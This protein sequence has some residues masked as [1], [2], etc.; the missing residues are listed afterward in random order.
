[1]S[2][3]VTLNIRGM[4]CASCVARLEK[5]LSKVAGVDAA[6]VNLATEKAQIRVNQEPQV[7]TSLLIAAVEK[8]GFEANVFGRQTINSSS[9]TT[10]SLVVVGG[11][12]ITGNAN[13]GGTVRITNTTDSSS[14][15]SGAL[16]VTGGVGIGGTLNV[17]VD[18]F[19]SADCSLQIDKLFANTA[20]DAVNK[21]NKTRK[22]EFN[23]RFNNTRSKVPFK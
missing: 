1:M 7:I 20:P 22:I 15:T 2:Q 21:N 17:G 13:I 10:G 5:S 14:T 12:G 11:L 8:A 4:T 18:L 6:S 16:I 3:L 19:I 9:T 23:E